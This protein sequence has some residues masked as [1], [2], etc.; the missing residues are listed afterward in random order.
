MSLPKTACPGV[1]YKVQQSEDLI[2][3]SIY[4]I[5]PEHVYVNSKT[6]LLK[7]LVTIMLCIT[8]CT[9]SIGASD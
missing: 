6:I 9:R 2:A 3:H 5:I 1:A 8:L 7:Y 4:V